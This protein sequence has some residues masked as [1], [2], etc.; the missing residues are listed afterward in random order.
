LSFAYEKV[1]AVIGRPIIQFVQKD[2]AKTAS[3]RHDVVRSQ[4]RI[5]GLGKASARVSVWTFNGRAA[6]P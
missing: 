6:C 3:A 5:S 1:S 4:E 2:C